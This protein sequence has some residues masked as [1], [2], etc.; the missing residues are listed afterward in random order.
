MWM[1][2]KFHGGLEYSRLP[3]RVRYIISQISYVID[4]KM[5]ELDIAGEPRHVVDRRPHKR[6]TYIDK[7][8]KEKRKLD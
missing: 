7:I 4:V 3:Q 6:H 1:W 2:G 5:Y 8:Y